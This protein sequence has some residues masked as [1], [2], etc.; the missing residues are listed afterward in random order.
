[1]SG[2]INDSTEREEFNKSTCRGKIDDFR[3]G[4]ANFLNTIV[5]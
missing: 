5:N 3:I 2:I 1:M 4:K